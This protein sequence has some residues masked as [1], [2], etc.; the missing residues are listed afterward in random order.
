MSKKYVLLLISL[1]AGLYCS[2]LPEPQR[3]TAAEEATYDVSRRFNNRQWAEVT[4]EN[5]LSGQTVVKMIS[6]HNG[7]KWIATSAGVDVYNG[8]T[9]FNIP[10]PGAADKVRGGMQSWWRTPPRTLSAAP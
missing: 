9:I 4:K 1:L 6:D 8:H 3:T 5:G 10:L 7:M 2:A